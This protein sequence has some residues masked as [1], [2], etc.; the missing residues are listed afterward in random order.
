MLTIGYLSARRT[1]KG[2]I[3]E[4]NFTEGP[5]RGA[6]LHR[7]HEDD[8]IIDF[9]DPGSVEAALHAIGEDG[10]DV[11]GRAKAPAP[12]SDRDDLRRSQ[13]QEDTEGDESLSVLVAKWIESRRLT[14]RIAPTAPPNPRLTIFHGGPE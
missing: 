10:D 14:I 13:L 5:C 4:R 12:S 3:D 6:I 1:P 8:S 7:R 2:S 9:S 11:D